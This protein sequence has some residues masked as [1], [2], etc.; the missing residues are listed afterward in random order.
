MSMSQSQ[1][2]TEH[3][4]TGGSILWSFRLGFWMK[5]CVCVCTCGYYRHALMTQINKCLL[6][7]LL[8]N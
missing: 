2:V 1:R 8:Y 3:H 7:L 5:L 4:R 6:L